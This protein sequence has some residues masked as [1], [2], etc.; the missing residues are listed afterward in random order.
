MR[1]YTLPACILMAFTPAACQQQPHT[2]HADTIAAGPERQVG[3]PCECCEAWRD[4]LPG[5]LSWQTT[6]TPDGEPGEVLAVSGTIFESDGKT[7]AEGVI[8]Y[9]YHT[10]YTGRYSNGTASTTCGRR[11][12]HLRGWMKT[13]SDGRY[14]FRTIRPASYPNS[15]IEQHIH[16]VIKEPGVR[17]YWIDAFVFDDDPYLTTDMRKHLDNRGGTGILHPVRNKQGIWVA[18][19]DI[20][21]GKNVPGY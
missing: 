4:G 18:E 3:G 8:L 7:P 15:K 20:V 10:D 16:P 2:E 21:L 13:G 6:I 14:R 9:V 11:H 17:E 5:A 19:R 1:T 12:G